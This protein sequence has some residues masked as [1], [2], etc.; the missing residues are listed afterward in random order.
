MN[1]LAKPLCEYGI[2]QIAQH[3]MKSCNP[4]KCPDNSY[5][6]KKIYKIYL[7]LLRCNKITAIKIFMTSKIHMWQDVIVLMLFKSWDLG[8]T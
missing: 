3:L 8:G 5:L 7:S 4:Y 1:S 6:S 2:Q